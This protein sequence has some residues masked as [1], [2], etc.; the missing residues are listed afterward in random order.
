M[1]KYFFVLLARK[2]IHKEKF[3]FHSS[4]PTKDDANICLTHAIQLTRF[5]PPSP[6]PPDPPTQN[7]VR[8]QGSLSFSLFS[9]LL[10]H[11]D[12]RNNKLN[13]LA[14]N[15]WNLNHKH[16]CSDT[17]TSVSSNPRAPTPS[18]WVLT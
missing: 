2:S 8:R 13:Q 15:L 4:N 14:V 7:T 1:G 18:V 12:L 9:S 10:A 6:L 3:P 16:G 5:H 17:R 11:G